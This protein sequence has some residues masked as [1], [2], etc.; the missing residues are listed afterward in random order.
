MLLLK[1]QHIARE[2]IVSALFIG[3]E[4]SINVDGL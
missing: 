4:K 2:L 1:E 3:S